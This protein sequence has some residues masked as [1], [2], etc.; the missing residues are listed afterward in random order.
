M[1]F[2]T[3]AQLTTAAGTLVL[4]VATFAATRSANRSTRLAEASLLAGLRPVLVPARL[5]DGRQKAG[6][7]D[8][9]WVMVEGAYASAEDVDGVVYLVLPV[10]N[11]G[12]GVAV[13]R[14]WHPVRDL[15]SARDGGPHEVLDEF[16][17]HQ[18]D[19]FIP[20]GDLGFW[21]AAM[22]DGDD[23]DQAEISATIA[24]RER[25]AVDVLYSDLHGGQRA[26]TRFAFSPAHDDR[27]LSTM[28]RHW[29]LDG[30]SVR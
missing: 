5:D 23:P 7:V 25:F 26:I 17:Y 14:G 9:H 8:Q 28:S 13:L 29:Q 15:M 30:P 18:R 27:W 2:E 4:A 24:A 12:S 16:R 21:E 10:R 20:A 11:A 22:R 1:N 3:A 19:M 6:F